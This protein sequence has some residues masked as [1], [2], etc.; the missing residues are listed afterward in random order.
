MNRLWLVLILGTSCFA[1][2]PL[3]PSAFPDLPKNIRA[4]LERRHCKIP[5]LFQEKKKVN[6]IRGQFSKPGQMDWAVMCQA[7]KTISILIFWN[8]SEINPARFA[9][10]NVDATTEFADDG[11]TGNDWNISTVGKRE[12]MA[13]YKHFGGPKPPSIDHDGLENGFAGKASSIS[14]FHGGKWLGWTSSD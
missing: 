3:L 9:S 10:S 4:D 7:G 8:G 11:T 1:Q 5:Q 13:S 6:V 2:A 12:I 14:Y